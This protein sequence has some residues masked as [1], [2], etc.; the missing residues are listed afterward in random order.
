MSKREL[1]AA[2]LTVLALDLVSCATLDEEARLFRMSET[3]KRRKAESLK[4]WQ[5]LQALTEGAEDADTVMKWASVATATLTSPPGLW[6]LSFDSRNDTWNVKLTRPFES[7]GSAAA[8]TEDGYFL[9]AAHCVSEESPCDIL[10]QTEDRGER[11]WAVAQVRVVWKSPDDSLDLALIHAPIR[12]LRP[13][14]LAHPANAMPGSSVGCV[15]SSCGPDVMKSAAAGKVLSVSKP[16]THA[17]GARYRII[18]SDV[19]VAQGDSGGPLFDAQANLLGV[20]GL[21]EGRSLMLG[22]KVLKV[23]SYRAHSQNLT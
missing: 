19:P 13:F 9:T 3:I 12:P 22:N 1:F 18:E 2:V 15:G 21:I 20:Q 16:R 8:L 17:S 4:D 10:A 11:K 7:A 5:S 6:H 23:F 14:D